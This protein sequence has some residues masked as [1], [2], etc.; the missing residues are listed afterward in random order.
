MKEVNYREDDWREAKS[1]LAPFAAAN[2]VGG[3]FNNLEKVS[4]NMEEAE[5]DIQ[6]LD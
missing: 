3:L 5:E 6:E 1:A 2:W 4:K